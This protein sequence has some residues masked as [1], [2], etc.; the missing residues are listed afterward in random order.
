MPVPALKKIAKKAHKPLKKIEKYWRAAKKE[1]GDKKSP[2]A[3][4]M[5]IVKKR[6]GVSKTLGRIESYL[7]KQI[8]SLSAE[9]GE[10]IKTGKSGQVLRELNQFR[11][12]GLVTLPEELLFFG[13]CQL[14]DN[15]ESHKYFLKLLKLTLSSKYRLSGGRK[16]YP[17]TIAFGLYEDNGLENLR[18]HVFLVHG[19]SA[20]ICAAQ[21]VEDAHT[22]VEIAEEKEGED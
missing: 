14:E 20:L 3:Y 5:G 16:I 4:R 2:W 18:L 22:F 1:G 13:S 17:A 21:A 15:K 12:K 9:E 7:D 19:T 8:A 10:T 11:R 6:A